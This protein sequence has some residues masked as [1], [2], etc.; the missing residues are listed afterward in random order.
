MAQKKSK[1]KTKKAKTTTKAEI[2]TTKAKKTLVEEVIENKPE[3]TGYLTP[4]LLQREPMEKNIPVAVIFHNKNA[5]SITL[6]CYVPSHEANIEMIIAG[7]I[8][9]ETAGNIKMISKS[10]SPESWITNLYKS[11]EFSGNPFIAEEAQPT[12]EA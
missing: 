12:Y 7:D 8:S 11:R 5:G 9:I 3:I 1:S 10:E 2:T 4:I 6:E